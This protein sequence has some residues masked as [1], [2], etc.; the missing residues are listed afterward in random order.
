MERASEQGPWVNKDMGDW[1]Q[2]GNTL[3]SELVEEGE[4]PDDEEESASPPPAVQRIEE[5]VP[6]MLQIPCPFG[7]E[8]VYDDERGGRVMLRCPSCRA[9]FSTIVNAECRNVHSHQALSAREREWVVVCVDPEKGQDTADLLFRGASGLELAVGDRFS[10]ISSAGARGDHPLWL[11]N[12]TQKSR[13][14]LS[15]RGSGIGFF[16]Q[17]SPP[18]S[19]KETVL[20]V[21]YILPAGVAWG[22]FNIFLVWWAA[23][24]AAIIIA[25]FVWRP[26][27]APVLLENGESSPLDRIFRR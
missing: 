20:L 7:H 15:G 9:L 21:G 18:V 10:L 13:W 5:T 2:A 26:F 8:H 22:L 19:R 4:L 11:V 3:V 23:L 14:A 1:V 25:L 27:V 6:G 12:H 16:Q 17:S 24:I